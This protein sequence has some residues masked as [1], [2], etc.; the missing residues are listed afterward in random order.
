[1][2]FVI[3]YLLN[4]HAEVRWKHVANRELSENTFQSACLMKN[5]LFKL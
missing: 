4:F 3:V 2:D 5:E 1:M